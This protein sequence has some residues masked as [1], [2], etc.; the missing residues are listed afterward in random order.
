VSDEVPTP[1]EWAGTRLAVAN[2]QPGS[3]QPPKA[4][5]LRWGLGR[6]AAVPAGLGALG[7]RGYSPGTWRTANPAVETDSAC[8][9]VPAR[10]W[11]LVSKRSPA[12][13]MKT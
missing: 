1:C 13:V 11:P 2:S 9:R 10:P 7:H 3:V 8:Q 4:P 5:G 6:G 12:T